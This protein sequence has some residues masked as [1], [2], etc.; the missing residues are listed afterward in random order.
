[1]CVCLFS[2]CVHLRYVSL[3]AV[4]PEFLRVGHNRIFVQMFL[5]CIFTLREA[6][7]CTWHCENTL[8]L[9]TVEVLMRHV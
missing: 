4:S 9:Y 8:G 2:H 1:M 5:L 3:L 6:S 7:V